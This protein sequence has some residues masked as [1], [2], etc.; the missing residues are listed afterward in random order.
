MQKE[1]AALQDDR[2][3]LNGLVHELLMRLHSVQGQAAPPAALKPLNFARILK[4]EQQDTTGRGVQGAKD[5]KGKNRF[6]SLVEDEAVKEK[7]KSEC[8][9]KRRHSQR[10]SESGSDDDSL[11]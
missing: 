2:N 4:H 1:I 5:D 3:K 6:K 11:A 9:G 8:S 7:E 10:D